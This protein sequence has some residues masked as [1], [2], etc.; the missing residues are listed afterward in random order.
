MTASTTPSTVDR[1]VPRRQAETCGPEP[2][3]SRAPAR[4][5]PRASTTQRAEPD[6]PLRVFEH[7][8]DSARPNHRISDATAARL[9]LGSLRITDA[10]RFEPR[11]RNEAAS[12]PAAGRMRPRWPFAPGRP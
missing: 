8:G 10:A 4:P 6:T 5:P 9:P 2:S 1:N 3:L 11:A 7:R 12:V